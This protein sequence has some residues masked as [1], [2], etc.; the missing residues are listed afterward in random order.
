M[1]S[2]FFLPKKK[3]IRTVTGTVKDPILRQILLITNDILAF[4]LSSA[5]LKEAEIQEHSQLWPAKLKSSLQSKTT[6]NNKTSPPEERM[7]LCISGVSSVI[8]VQTEGINCLGHVRIKKSFFFFVFIIYCYFPS[9]G[10]WVITKS[11]NRFFFNTCRFHSFICDTTL[12]EQFF[13]Y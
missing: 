8:G 5:L 13:F 10:G 9:F 3:I 11:G 7:G 4:F 6:T 2:F 12:Q 1:S